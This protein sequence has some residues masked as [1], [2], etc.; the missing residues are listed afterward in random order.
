MV[1]KSSTSPG[2][3]PASSPSTRAGTS[4]RWLAGRW[5]TESRT[6]A[7]QRLGGP[8]A[9]AGRRHALGRAARR[10]RGGEVTGVLDRRQPAGEADPLPH[11][12]PLPVVAAEDQHRLVP[13]PTATRT[14]TRSPN[15]PAIRR[16]SAETV[17]VSVAR[18]RCWAASATGPSRTDSAR[19]QRHRADA[20]GH[21]H[22]GE[23]GE[24]RRASA[25]PPS[26]RSRTTATRPNEPATTRPAASAPR[27]LPPTPPGRAAACAGRCRPFIASRRARA[28]PG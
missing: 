22:H 1:R 4:A 15:R 9:G 7:P 16:G 24:G 13:R 28:W 10:H 11:R 18:A 23:R 20:G 26:A 6:D 19:G 14:S 5:A 21:R 8:P 17:P 3:I 25:A 12:Q 27:A 2:G